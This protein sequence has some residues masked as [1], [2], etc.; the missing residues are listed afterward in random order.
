MGDIHFAIFFL[1]LNIIHYFPCGSSPLRVHVNF[2]SRHHFFCS[3]LIQQSASFLFKSA[4]VLFVPLTLLRWHKQFAHLLSVWSGSAQ[5]GMAEEK[6]QDVPN[7]TARQCGPKIWSPKCF[8][9]S[10]PISALTHI[11]GETFSVDVFA[12]KHLTQED[13]KHKIPLCAS[14]SVRLRTTPMALRRRCINSARRG[15]GPSPPSGP[16]M[17]SFVGRH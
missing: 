14:P 8:K 16:V 15:N 5:R 17:G 11:G 4:R 7:M 2:V 12:E 3:F 1:K 10:Q 9:T 6:P 13:A